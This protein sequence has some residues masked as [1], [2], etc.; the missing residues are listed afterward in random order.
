MRRSHRLHKAS[1]L[2]EVLFAVFLVAVCATILAASMPT[3]SRSQKVADLNNK[4][5]NLGQKEL[6]AIRSLGYANLTPSQLLAAQL[7]DS[8]TPTA[9]NTYAFTNTDGGVNDSVAQRLPAGTATV[10]IEQVDIDLRRVT[11]TVNYIYRGS[12][13]SVR[14]GTLVANL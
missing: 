1:T 13:R 7:I 14:L 11:V 3:A 8:A 10:T 5:T 6:E 12:A 2:L 9:T 4:A